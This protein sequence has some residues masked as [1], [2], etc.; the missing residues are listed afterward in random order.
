MKEDSYK[1]RN[2]KMTKQELLDFVHDNFMLDKASCKL[3]RIIF[4][5][6][7]GKYIIFKHEKIEVSEDNLNRLYLRLKNIEEK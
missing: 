7:T 2:I 4:S 3:K 6:Y 1:R 5:T